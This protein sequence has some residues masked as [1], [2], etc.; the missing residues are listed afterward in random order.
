MSK[1]HRSEWYVTLICYAFE[2]GYRT[3]S[4]ILK[5]DR[6]FLREWWRGYEYYLNSDLPKVIPSKNNKKF[7][8]I[9][10]IYN[11]ASLI[12]SVKYFGIRK[13]ALFF[14]CSRNTVRLWSRRYLTEITKAFQRLPPDQG[15]GRSVREAC[16]LTRAQRLKGCMPENCDSWLYCRVRIKVHERA[17][18][19]L[20]MFPNE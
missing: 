13:T 12:I 14:N 20:P 3:A 5:C 17:Q 15:Y 2:Y 16:P 7:K 8:R 10:R 19:T 4:R 9:Y 1:K 6:P 11:R 18:L